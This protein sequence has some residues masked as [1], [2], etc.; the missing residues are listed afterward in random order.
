MKI[1]L[2][3]IITIAAILFLIPAMAIGQGTVNDDS[4]LNPSP[5][6][7]DRPLEVGDRVRV[8]AG[9]HEGRTGVISKILDYNSGMLYRIDG[10][11]ED[12]SESSE[13]YANQLERVELHEEFQGINDLIEFLRPGDS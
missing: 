12:Y 3:L 2:A 1:H 7:E 5:L 6:T 4:D 9:Q 11:P 10:L 13:Y 8:L